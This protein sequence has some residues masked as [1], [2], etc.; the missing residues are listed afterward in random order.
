M[1]DEDQEKKLEL[2][3]YDIHN[4]NG[5]RKWALFLSIVGF[6]FLAILVLFGFSLGTIMGQLGDETVMEGFPTSL[7]GIIYLI[8]GLIYFFPILFLFQFAVNARK[9]I[10]FMDSGFLSQAFKKLKDHY[11]YIGILMAIML[12]LYVFF[13]II[14]AVVLIFMK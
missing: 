12:G 9:G 8:I 11:T 1:N 7:F 13:G 14:M 3:R 2:T 5:I 10:Q 4:L 6:I